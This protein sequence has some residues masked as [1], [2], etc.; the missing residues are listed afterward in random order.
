MIRYN[1]IDNSLFKQNRKTL[2]SKLKPGSV[3]IFLSNYQMPRNGDQYFPYRQNSDFF[4]LTGIEQE[5]SV[6]V[7]STDAPINELNEVLFI[8]KNSPEMETWQ[9]HKL[10]PE[11]ATLVSGIKTI[12]IL[13]DFREVLHLLI[14]SAEYICLNVPIMPKFNPQ[15]KSYDAVLADELKT[16][17]PLHKFE[18][19]APLMQLLRLKKSQ[20]EIDLIRKSIGI[21]GNTFIRVLNEL[22]PGMYEYEIEA[23][24]QYEFIRSGSSG[25]AYE[26]IVAAGRN[27]CV[28]HYIANN[29]I[30][31]SGDLLLLDFGAEYANYA[32][33][34][35]R[36]IPVDGKFNARQRLLYDAT[37]RILKFAKSLMK[38]GTSINSIH[39]EVCKKWEEE[40]LQLG[41]YTQQELKDNKGEN[42]LWT[43]YYM[44]G[45]SH[46]LGLDVHDVGSKETLLEPGMVLTCE[47]GIYIQEENIGIRIEN[48]ILITEDGNEDLMENIPIEVEEIEMLR[49]L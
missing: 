14:S 43:R 2:K 48:N 38:P 47:P 26:P 44:H 18:Q 9:G 5:K 13:D 36:T 41:L 20:V 3:A 28:L 35:S 40:H 23:I 6:L 32:A 15:V 21:T 1:T 11:E 29:C 8:L 27:A 46:F 33:D 4:Y 7:V 42:P 34:L 25:Y 49:L 39:K 16:S 45:T 10:T 37:L 24:I 12:K 22:R 19:L 30:C 17:Y 31:K